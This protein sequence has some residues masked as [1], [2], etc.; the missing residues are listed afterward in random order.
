[1][2]AWETTPGTAKHLPSKACLHACL[3]DTCRSGR[4]FLIRQ[5]PAHLIHRIRVIV[6]AAAVAAAAVGRLRPENG[7]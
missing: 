2:P 3:G 5:L 1:M 7:R 4:P 6:L